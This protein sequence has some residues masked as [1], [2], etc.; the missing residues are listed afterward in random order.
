MYIFI[1]YKYDVFIILMLNYFEKYLYL[2]IIFSS[3]I[4]ILTFIY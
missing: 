2:I 3:Y 1:I 4:N